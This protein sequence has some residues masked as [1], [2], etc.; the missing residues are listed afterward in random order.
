MVMGEARLLAIYYLVKKHRQHSPTQ[1]PTPPAVDANNKIEKWDR[2]IK[3][4]DRL[5]AIGVVLPLGQIR[6]F[7]FTKAPSSI[8]QRRVIVLYSPNKR[9][10][11][12]RIGRLD[13]AQRLGVTRWY[14]FNRS[15]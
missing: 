2:T 4:E 1:S 15:S 8:Y 9:R 6:T 3:P 14:H 7:G 13:H 12:S 10:M 11:K 5:R